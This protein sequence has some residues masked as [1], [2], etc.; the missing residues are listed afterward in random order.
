MAGV[1]DGGTLPGSNII[2]FLLREM[3]TLKIIGGYDC[4]FTDTPHDRLICRI[5]HLPSREPYLSVCC[6]HLFCKSCLDNI[7]NTSTITYAC[8]ICRDTEFVTFPNKQADRE[9]KSL[10]IYCTNKE[11]GCE[12]QGELN[13][14]NNHLG[15]SDGCQFEEVKCSNEC[16]KMIE[17]RYLTS[18]VE[19]ECPRR[20]GNCQYC[21]DTGEHQFIEGR[22]KEECPKLPLPCPN[23]CEVGS[24]PREDMEAHRKECKLEIVKCLNKCGKQFERQN[25]IAHMETECPNRTVECPH[26]RGLGLHSWINGPIHRAV[27]PKLPLPCPNNCEVGSIP[28]ED[29]E[30]HRKECPLE[31]IQCEYHNVGCEVRMA[32]KDQEKHE[33]DNMKEHLKITELVLT[34]VKLQLS[35]TTSELSDT[36]LELVDTKVQLM[37]SKDQLTNA[38]QR[39]NNLEVLLFLA[40]N[41]AVARPT[42]NTVVLESSLRWS[43]KLVAMVMMSKSGDQECPVI[44]KTPTFKQQQKNDVSWY[45]NSF[46]THDKGYKMCL[47]VDPAGHGEGEG[48][49]LSVYL[50]LMKGPNDDKLTWPLMGKFGIQLLNQISDVQHHSIMVTYDEVTPKNGAS[51]VMNGDCAT[52][53]WGRSQVILIK[54]LRKAT[55]TCQYLKE[56]SLFFQVTKL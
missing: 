42:S 2:V 56:N 16:G 52:Y 27:C 20:K 18:H 12:W 22:H 8:P 30:A 41:K 48:T 17:R 32:R 6:G 3:V 45:S 39:I 11:K 38:L 36:K 54:D 15:N 19:T 43:D 47:N 4:S 28:R 9:I 37:S 29:M 21:H 13:Y 25:L 44:I 24:V 14:I 49:Y 23:K 10:H 26:C 31:M 5:C 50:L 55:P 1:I 34:D 51:R 7:K 35:S 53:G 46:Y 33:N 40:T